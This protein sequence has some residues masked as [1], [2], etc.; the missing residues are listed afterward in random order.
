[1]LSSSLQGF[2]QMQSMGSCRHMPVLPPRLL[3]DSIRILEAIKAEKDSYR[4][5]QVLV[6]MKGYPLQNA[7]LRVEGPDSK[8]LQLDTGHQEEHKDLQS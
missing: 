4:S 7:H 5:S 3:R 6:P 1:M 2:I 8:Q